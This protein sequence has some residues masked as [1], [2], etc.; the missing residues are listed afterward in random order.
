MG[1]IVNRRDAGDQY[2]IS[3]FAVRIIIGNDHTLQ[4]IQY[5]KHHSPQLVKGKYGYHLKE[6]KN[7]SIIVVFGSERVNFLPTVQIKELYN[8]GYYCAIFQLN[9][10]AFVSM[11]NLEKYYFKFLIIPCD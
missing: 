2:K 8:C 4:T 5:L 3:Y 9:M 11:S 10:L 1:I 7:T 6:F